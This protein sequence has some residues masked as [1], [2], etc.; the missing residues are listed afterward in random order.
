LKGKKCA[1]QTL[2]TPCI[3]ANISKWLI[4]CPNIQ[5]R[6]LPAIRQT[7]K[8]DSHFLVSNFR[9]FGE[10]LIDV[11]FIIQFI[12]ARAALHSLGDGC[13]VV[14]LQERRVWRRVEHIW[15][16]PWRL[17]FD[18]LEFDGFRMERKYFMGLLKRRVRDRTRKTRFTD[19]SMNRK[20]ETVIILMMLQAKQHPILQGV[21]SPGI[22]LCPRAGTRERIFGIGGIG[23]RI[24]D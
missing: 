22:L 1:I 9:R 15:A 6:N 8:P 23:K 21:N 7:I 18:A 14:Y 2:T 19:I 5:Q 20:A 11:I 3:S 24:S 12:I 4:F 17:Y 16:F 13:E 10:L